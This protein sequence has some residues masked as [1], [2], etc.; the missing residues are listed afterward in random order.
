MLGVGSILGLFTFWGMWGWGLRSPM[1]PL[2]PTGHR[3]SAAARVSKVFQTEHG[4]PFNVSSSSEWVQGEPCGTT[5]K[6][7]TL[8]GKGRTFLSLHNKDFSLAP[9]RPLDAAE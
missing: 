2:S 3:G 7:R 6:T 4:E 5:R 1:P 8:G 9:I